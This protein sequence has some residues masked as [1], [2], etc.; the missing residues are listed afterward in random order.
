MNRLQK[1]GLTLIA[2]ALAAGLPAAVTSAQ[3]PVV[4]TEE[5][6]ASYVPENGFVPDA[7]TATLIAEAVLAPIYGKHTVRRER[8]FSAS[9]QGQ[10]W[11]VTGA[12]HPGFSLWPWYS[13]TGGTALVQIDKSDGR[14]LRVIHGE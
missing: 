12:F 2:G 13:T 14:I 7:R 11:I 10:T 3:S 6:E 5:S 9:L 4:T 8:P 1:V